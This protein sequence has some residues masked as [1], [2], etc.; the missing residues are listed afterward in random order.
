MHDHGYTYAGHTRPQKKGSVAAL[1][2]FTV[3]LLSL[4]TRRLLRVRS[5]SLS[6]GCAL[7]EP[8][9]SLLRRLGRV[10]S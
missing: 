6:C 4:S 5:D 10:E 7:R 3:L 8:A 9:L 1:R 2:R